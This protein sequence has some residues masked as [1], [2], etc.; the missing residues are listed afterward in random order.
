MGALKDK[1]VCLFG[2]SM[3]E[4]QI[5]ELFG[6]VFCYFFLPQKVIAHHI[7]GY[8]EHVLML[9]YSFSSMG[10]STLKSQS[11]KRELYCLYMVTGY[12]K[13]VL[14]HFLPHQ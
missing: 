12:C 13:E 14:I 4:L 11:F 9:Y 5:E 1:S 10:I 8:S 3:N 6:A 2:T 7:F